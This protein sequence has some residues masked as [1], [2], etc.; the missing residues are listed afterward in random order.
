MNLEQGV[1]ALNQFIEIGQTS[2]DLPP[3]AWAHLRLAQLAKLL[4][5]PVM[6]EQHL[7]KAMSS[8]DKELHRIARQLKRQTEEA[9]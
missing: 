9:A 6:M 7:K 4:N 8:D 5:E 2:P 1:G 3:L